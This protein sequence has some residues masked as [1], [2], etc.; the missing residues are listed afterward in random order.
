LDVRLVA[1]RGWGD[2][3]IQRLGIVDGSAT[4]TTFGSLKTVDSPPYVGDKWALF[5]WE[6]TFR[7]IPFEWLSWRW[8]IERHWNVILTGGHGWADYDG[9]RIPGVQTLSGS[10]HHEAGISLSGLF[11]M[12]RLDT[13]WRLDAPGFRVGISTARIF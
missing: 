4:M 8:P 5:A 1:G 3:P 11:T 12:F 2:A 9:A 7:T 10:W 6:H 13:S